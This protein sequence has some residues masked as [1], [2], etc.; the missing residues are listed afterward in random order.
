[1]VGVLK[2]KVRWVATSDS[3]TLVT[4]ALSPLAALQVLDLEGDW[5][6]NAHDRQMAELYDETGDAPAGDDEKPLWDDDIDIT[7]IVPEEKSSKKKKKKDKKKKKHAE[8]DADQEG[9][10]LDEMDADVQKDEAFE[11][12][13]EWDGTEEMRKKALDKYMDELYEMEFNDLVSGQF[14]AFLISN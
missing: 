2:T 13:E 5:D 10:D 11:A 3:M 14:R 8:D 9:V 12:D 7:D 6:P 1:M 4:D